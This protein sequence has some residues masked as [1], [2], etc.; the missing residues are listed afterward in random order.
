MF[1][2]DHE[3]HLITWNVKGFV[4]FLHFGSICYYLSL[5]I[6]LQNTRVAANGCDHRVLWFFLWFYIQYI[7]LL[8]AIWAMG[9]GRAQTIFWYLDQQILGAKLWNLFKVNTEGTWRTPIVPL[10]FRSSSKHGLDK[11]SFV[12]I[13]WHVTSNWRRLSNKLLPERGIYFRSISI[14]TITST[15]G[16]MKILVT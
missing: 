12:K 1:L 7:S 10:V 14:V 9:F 4:S 16:Y 13:N 6:N 15:S 11:C 5:L 3:N 8:K 2:F